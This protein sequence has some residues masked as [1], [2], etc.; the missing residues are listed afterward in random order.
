MNGK[1]QY[2]VAK[3][4]EILQPKTVTVRRFTV[5]EYTAGLY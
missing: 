4:F 1:L 2:T 5:D 3:M